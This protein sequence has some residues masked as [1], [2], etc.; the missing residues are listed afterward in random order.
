MDSISRNFNI[1]LMDITKE[2]KKE[3]G[4]EEAICISKWKFTM[5]KG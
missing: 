5:L 2:E 3:N 1:C 4:R